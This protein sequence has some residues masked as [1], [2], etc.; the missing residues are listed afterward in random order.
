MHG[1]FGPFFS[2]LKL[3]LGIGIR[4]GQKGSQLFWY[5]YCDVYTVYICT[6]M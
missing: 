1:I 2:D 3:R 5:M 6:M 4:D